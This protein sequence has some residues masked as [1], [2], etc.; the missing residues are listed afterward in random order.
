MMAREAASDLNGPSVGGWQQRLARELDNLRA[1]LGWLRDHGEPA[2]GLDLATALGMFW[3]GRGLAA[4]GLGWLRVF[5]SACPESGELRGQALDD[6]SF[7]AFLCGDIEE[8]RHFAEESLRIAREQGNA[9]QIGR[10][11]G[12]LSRVMR[13]DRDVDQALALSQEGIAIARR[14]GDADLLAYHLLQRAEAMRMAHN[15]A[16]ARSL[17]RESLEIYRTLGQAELAVHNL[18]NLIEVELDEG[19]LDQAA[20]LHREK[21]AAARQL[22]HAQIDSYTVLE[23]A[24]L[25]AGRDNLLLAARLLAAATRMLQ[26]MG[27]V[28]DPPEQAGYDAT[29]ALVRERF[30]AVALAALWE[31]GEAMSL[32]QAEEYALGDSE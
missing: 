31:E 25:A 22:H 30:D 17:Y 14:T 28:I 23:S 18:H 16:E 8:A 5:L 7:I 11:L 26:S 2:A 20:K 9:R 29:L 3:M 32:E 1:A 27:L 10:A 4:E 12:S 19:N 24:R 21:V 13:A 6:A 15:T